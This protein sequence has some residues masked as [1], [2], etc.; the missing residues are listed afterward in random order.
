VKLNRLFLFIFLFPLLGS[1][2]TPTLVQHVSCPNSRNG[3]NQQSNTPDYKCPLP[4]PAQAGNAIIVGVVAVN[5]GAFTLSDDKSNSYT[6][7]TTVG[8]SNNGY[9]AIYVATNV[10]GGT[11]MIKLHRTTANAFN[12]AMSASEYYN[13]ALS[14]AIDKASC[15]GSSGSSSTT[16]TAGSITPSVGGDLLWQWA[17]NTGGG[18]A[19]PNSV[20]SFTVGSQASIPWQFN[21][22]DLYDGD[23]VQ[24][25]VYNS[26]AAIN[27]TFTAGSSEEWTSCAVA[28]KAAATGAGNAPTQAFRIVHMLHQQMA[29]SGSNPFK[30]QFPASGNLIVA[31]YISGGSLI[32]SATSTPS[33]TWS[34]TGTASGGQ[35]ITAASQIYYAAN[36]STSNSMTIS[37]TKDTNTSDGTYMMYDIVGAATSPF[38]K[39]SGPQSANQTS[40]VSS[41]TPSGAGL[42]PTGVSGGKEIVVGNTGWNWCT[43]NGVTSP[44]GALFDVATD[45]GNSVNGP[46]P[47]DQNNG[48]FHLY[49]ASTSALTTTWSPMACSQAEGLWAGR[50]AAFK[51]A[52][53]VAQQPPPPTL[54]QAV[55]N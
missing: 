6:L 25:A 17:V 16:I 36:A 12:V 49:T 3:G 2:Q 55:V 34:S 15:N 19:L 21:G 31:S 28:L 47:V 53:S 24:A 38:D 46:E 40:Q 14:S 1:A 43:A 13:V 4:E 23:A 44:V 33:N 30:I 29:A 37:F 9:V 5:T 10:A 26:T 18:N 42:T 32:T 54:L 7:A 45:T 41:F 20:T 8:D 52:S 11:R 39:D 22:T 50:V 27:P 51:S 48:W 35:S